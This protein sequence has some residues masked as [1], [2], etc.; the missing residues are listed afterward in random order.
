MISNKIYI[1]I[2]WPNVLSDSLKGSLEYD[3]AENIL[4]LP[5]DQRYD[6]YDMEYIIKVIKK[7]VCL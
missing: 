6:E 5:C 3:M 2:L 4:P 7:E 1:P